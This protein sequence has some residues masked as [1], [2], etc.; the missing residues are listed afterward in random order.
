MNEYT[1]RPAVLSDMPRLGHIMA[2]SFRAAFSPFLSLE[3]I[4]ESTEEHNCTALLEGLFREGQMR[5]LT[6]GSFG[7]LVWMLHESG[8][9]EIMA[10]HTLPEHWGTG[11]GHALLT[12]AMA[13]IGARPLF[14][15]A[16]EENARGRRFYE[17][18]GLRFDG[19]A[20]PSEFGATEV[21]YRFP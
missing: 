10:I 2:R 11:L 21:R 1:I 6:D 17:K 13:E 18:H 8:E 19:A 7:L 14:L 9:A 4:D 5:F 16:F 20:R 3:S 15:W 12:A